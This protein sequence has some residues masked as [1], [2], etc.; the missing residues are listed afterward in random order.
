MDIL[1][2][3]TF[4]AALL[5]LGFVALYLA[6]KDSSNTAGLARIFREF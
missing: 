4:I 2:G 1:V 6:N 3:V 5:Y